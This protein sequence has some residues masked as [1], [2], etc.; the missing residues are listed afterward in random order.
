[1]SVC[2]GRSRLS[3]RVSLARRMHR[4]GWITRGGG[5]AGK[6]ASSYHNRGQGGS[7]IG[8]GATESVIRKRASGNNSSKAGRIIGAE[9]YDD[10]ARSRCSCHG[11]CRG[12]IARGHLQIVDGVNSPTT[13]E[14]M[15]DPVVS[16]LKFE[17]CVRAGGLRLK[18]CSCSIGTRRRA[19]CVRRSHTVR[20]SIVGGADDGCGLD[21]GCWL[22]GASLRLS[23]GLAVELGSL[24]AWEPHPCHPARHVGRLFH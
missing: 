20:F 6:G 19:R 5:L 14:D 8:T 9:Y 1:M 18:V 13:L 12:G 7:F 2:S 4:G 22:V 3:I 17:Q 10:G 15:D 21:R 11:Y 24:A 16:K 23:C